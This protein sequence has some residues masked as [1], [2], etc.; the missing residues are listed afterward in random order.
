MLIKN[1][2]KRENYFK[3]KILK[4]KFEDWNFERLFKNGSSEN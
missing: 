4:I 3:I 1:S 2:E